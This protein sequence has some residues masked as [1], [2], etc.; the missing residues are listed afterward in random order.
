MGCSARQITQQ[1]A[2]CSSKHQTPTKLPFSSATCPGWKAG[3]MLTPP[4]VPPLN[5]V[6]FS[7]Y[8]MDDVS[9]MSDTA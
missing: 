4:Q 2:P 3:C 1:A 7:H 5:D 8:L 9:T 6:T